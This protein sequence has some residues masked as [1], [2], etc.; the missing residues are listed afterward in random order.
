[1]D[2]IHTKG[3]YEV[4]LEISSVELQKQM[5]L[6]PESKLVSSYIEA[7]C[8]IYDDHLFKEFIL[9]G[10]SKMKFT[11]EIIRKLIKLDELLNDFNEIGDNYQYDKDII[12][13]KNWLI[14]VECAK[15]IIKIWPKEFK[16]DFLKY[17]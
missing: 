9:S 12:D 2:L 5:W 17:L 1:M 6:N 4:I 3:I 15:E 7:M 16:S 11:S 8:S 10:A 14:I 13:D